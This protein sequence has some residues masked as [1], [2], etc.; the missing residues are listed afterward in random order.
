MKMYNNRLVLGLSAAF[1]GIV[2]TT[3]EAQATPAFARQM[4]MNCLSCHTQALTTLNPFGRQFKLTGY[5]M[6]KGDKSMI[7]GGDLGTS[8]P[9]AIN[10]G[11]GVKSNYM[12][13]NQPTGRDSLSAPAG[14]AIMIGGKLA[15]DAGANTLWNGDGLIHM[16][17]TFTHAIEAGRIGFSVYGG[18]G[19]GPFISTES[20]NT[21]LH[22]ELGIFE[23]SIKTNAAQATGVGSGPASGITVFYGGHGLTVTGGI[24]VKGFNSSF[25]NKGLDSD[26]IDQT[27][28][29]ISYDA[30]EMGAWNLSVGAFG[31]GGETTGTPCKLWENT[32]ALFTTCT[33]TP[34]AN[35]LT[36]FE[37]TASGLDMQAQ[38]SIAGMDTLVVINHVADWEYRITDAA[39]PTTVR[40]NQELS[41]TSIEAR[42]MVKPRFG[43]SI[44]QMSFDDKVASTNADYSTMSLGLLYNYADNVRFSLDRTSIDLDTGTDYD[45]TVAQVLLAF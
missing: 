2:L 44:G 5:S 13:T 27:L 10:A 15:E 35:S 21:G 26:G 34:W 16:Q 6:A 33:G 45:E 1:M 24:W 40:S 23:N 19:H 9:L 29:R 38:G 31:L 14:V 7:T 22:K 41:A 28:Y 3:P 43:V 39:T 8:V 17:T 30:P 42:M 25:A 36:K 18:Q 11:M 37:T 32:A 20:Y 12:T 4:E